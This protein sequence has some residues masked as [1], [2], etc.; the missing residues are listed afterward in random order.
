[1]EGPIVEYHHISTRRSLFRLR[2]GPRPPDELS[3]P[4][5]RWPS[6]DRIPSSKARKLEWKVKDS[7]VGSV[8]SVGSSLTWF[9]PSSSTNLACIW[10]FVLRFSPQPHPARHR[11]EFC[12]QVQPL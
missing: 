2:V 9:A 12:H 1:M 11:I 5:L 6:A 4:V 10:R 8:G 3:E 7:P